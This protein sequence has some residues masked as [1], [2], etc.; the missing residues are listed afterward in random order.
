MP[1]FS[2]FYAECNYAEAIMLS[3][4]MLSVVAPGYGKETS[5]NAS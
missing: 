4:I 2:V 3:V 1:L 5:L